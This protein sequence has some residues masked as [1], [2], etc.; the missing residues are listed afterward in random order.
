MGVLFV[1]DVT[2]RRKRPGERGRTSHYGRA[3]VVFMSDLVVARGYS[4]ESQV[5]TPA[6]AVEQTIRDDHGCTQST[7]S[8]GSDYKTKRAP[9]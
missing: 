5:Y 2:L 4:S 9:D 1:S 6:T 8:C 3:L 7:F